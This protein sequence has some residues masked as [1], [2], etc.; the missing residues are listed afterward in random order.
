MTSR[1][2]DQKPSE[3]DKIITPE[4]S[5]M[6]LLSYWRGKEHQNVLI[7][8]LLLHTVSVSFQMPNFIR[9]LW[10]GISVTLNFG[11]WRD[12]TI[13]HYSVE[14]N[15]CLTKRFILKIDEWWFFKIYKISSDSFSSVYMQLI[16]WAACN[17]LRYALSI[18]S[19]ISLQKLS[20]LFGKIDRLLEAKYFRYREG[21]R[22]EHK[23]S[24]KEQRERWRKKYTTR[25]WGPLCSFITNLGDLG[26]GQ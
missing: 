10:K 16:S 6:Q 2:Q 13:F 15:K 12:G 11:L 18:T 23:E 14:A 19:L 21:W 8:F 20:K 3:T 22:E 25:S 4:N 1:I 9:C 7:L 26:W 17:Y 5:F 24:M